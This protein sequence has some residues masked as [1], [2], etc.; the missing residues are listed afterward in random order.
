MTYKK[1]EIFG[2]FNQA[3]YEFEEEIDDIESGDSYNIH[4]NICRKHYK[5]LNFELG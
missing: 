5:E 2:C 4:Y 1:C 3:T